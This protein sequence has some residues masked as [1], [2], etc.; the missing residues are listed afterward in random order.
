M[1]IIHNISGYGTAMTSGITAIF[2]YTTITTTT[3]TPLGL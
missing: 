2:G 3:I 1:N